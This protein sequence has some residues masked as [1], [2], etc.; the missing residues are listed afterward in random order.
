[1][2]QYT[3]WENAKNLLKRSIIRA[4][5]LF[6]KFPVSLTASIENLANTVDVKFHCLFNQVH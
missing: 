3:Y 6:L 5:W 2:F 4:I 1:M